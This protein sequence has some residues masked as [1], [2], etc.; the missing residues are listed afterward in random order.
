MADKLPPLC[1][2]HANC[3]DGFAAAWVVRYALPSAELVAANYGSAPPD[4]TGR[5][6]YIVDFSYPRDVLLVMAS[7][8][9]KIFVLDHHKTAA[10]QLVDLPL[11]VRTRFDM[12]HSGCILAWQHF[13]GHELPPSLLL[14]IE[15][16][17]LWEFNMDRT[18]EVFAGLMSY[19][20]E[21]DVW[22]SMMWNESGDLAIEG[23]GI[24]R[25]QRRDLEALLPN[26]RM[27]EIAGHQVPSLNAPFFMASDAGAVLTQGQPFA[28]VYW[29]TA[30]G[31]QYSLRSAPDGIDVAE[32]A[33]QFGG[34]G[35][36]HAAGFKVTCDHYLAAAAS[37]VSATVKEN[38]TV[39]STTEE[40]S[41]V[42]EASASAS[43]R[44]TVTLGR[45]LFRFDSYEQ[46]VN[47]ARSWFMRAG[48]PSAQ[49]VCIDATGRVCS[50]G[51]HFMSAR[52]RGAFPVVAYRI[53]PDG[54]Y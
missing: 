27:I 52:D 3:A 40:C 5:I 6:V 18:R 42:G 29:D 30:H 49:V 33:Q 44:I 17:D 39:G 10:E 31:R 36:K 51:M 50:L 14:H 20:Y 43:V 54:R 45:E 4:V 1:I 38:L 16:Q 28:A 7:Q 24:L 21:F 37:H 13:F 9:E 53:D 19:P 8:A 12:S 25:K 35:H 26:A 11:N 32:I 2:Y 22:G 47:K 23:E 34:G 15:D 41:V 46:W 48:V